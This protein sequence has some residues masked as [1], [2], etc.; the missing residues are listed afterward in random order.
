MIKDGIKL[1][2]DNLSNFKFKI[3]QKDEIGEIYK[4]IKRFCR[5]DFGE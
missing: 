2:K 1:M 3:K 5:P 4:N